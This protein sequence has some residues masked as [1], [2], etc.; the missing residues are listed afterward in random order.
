MDEVA[1]PLTRA[2]NRRP[3]QPWLT[4]QTCFIRW[5]SRCAKR[6]PANFLHFKFMPKTYNLALHHVKQLYFTSLVSSLCHNPKRLFN[7][8]HFL[9]SPKEQAPVIDLT[10]GELAAYFKEKN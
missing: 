1:L 9:L 4:S 3:R 7:T 10:A 2:V 6:L 5:C 8:F